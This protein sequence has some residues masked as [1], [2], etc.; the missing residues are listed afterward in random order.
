MPPR[1]QSCWRLADTFKVSDPAAP[2]LSL[3]M[4][5][6]MKGAYFNTNHSFSPLSKSNEVLLAPKPGVSNSVS[7]RVTLGNENHINCQTLKYIYILTY[8]VQQ[9]PQT[10]QVLILLF[11]LYSVKKS[12]SS[13]IV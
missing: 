11:F 9:N 5:Y 7:L 12:K 2:R 4:I 10:S 1:C 8:H 6:D 13:L 3:W